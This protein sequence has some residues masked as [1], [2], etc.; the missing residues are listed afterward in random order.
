MCLSS[1]FQ[2][3]GSSL[4]MWTENLQRN[5]SPLDLQ[6]D[7]STYVTR[8]LLEILLAVQPRQTDGYCPAVPAGRSYA[9]HP[10]QRIFGQ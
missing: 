2:N 8:L 7:M 6:D 10:G 1:G 5:T 3:I 4:L 9:T